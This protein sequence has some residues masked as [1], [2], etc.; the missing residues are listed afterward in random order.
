MRVP[1]LIKELERIEA[2]SPGL[3]VMVDQ[4]I[5]DE[6]VKRGLK[7]RGGGKVIVELK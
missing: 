7:S 1:E 3:V 6:V 4:K 2:E 5:V